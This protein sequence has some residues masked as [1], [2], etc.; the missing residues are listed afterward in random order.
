LFIGGTAGTFAADFTAVFGAVLAAANGFAGSAAK[1]ADAKAIGSH[2]Y[3]YLIDDFTSF[4]DD[5]RG[6]PEITP[7]PRFA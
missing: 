3:R 1:L 7:A 4:N 6:W 5:A 2:A